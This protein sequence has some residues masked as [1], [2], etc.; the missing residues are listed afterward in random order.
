[1]MKERETRLTTLSPNHVICSLVLAFVRSPGR[2]FTEQGLPGAAPSPA[3]GTLMDTKAAPMLEES[4]ICG[5]GLSGRLFW[6][7]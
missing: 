5:A 4:F 6:A 2:R 3:P 1:M 7:F